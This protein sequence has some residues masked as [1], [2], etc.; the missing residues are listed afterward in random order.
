MNHCPKGRMESSKYLQIVEAYVTQSVKKL[1]LKKIKDRNPK[2]P[3][4]MPAE[5]LEWP[6]QFPD[7]NILKNIVCRKILNMLCMQD[8]PRLYHNWKRSTMKGRVGENPLNK[9]RKKKDSLL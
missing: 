5:T 8:G 9:N 4:E 6:S 2:L 3:Q 1:K 7:L